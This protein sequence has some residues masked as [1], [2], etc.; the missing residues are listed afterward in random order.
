M[1]NVKSFLSIFGCTL[2]YCT[3]LCVPALADQCS[4]ITKEQA[5]TAVSR[6][7]LNQ[8]IYLLC[9]PCGEEIPKPT[10][11]ENLSIEIVNYQDYWQVKVNDRGIDLAYV[12]IDSGIDGNLIN[13]AAISDCQA[14]SVSTVL[15]K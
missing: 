10:R 5:L 9:E 7:N 3:L 2:S 4:Y 14:R 1:I 6:L 8:T 15:E 11:I 13:L 12:F